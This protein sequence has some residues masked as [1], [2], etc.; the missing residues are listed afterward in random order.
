MMAPVNGTAHNAVLQGETPLAETN[1]F[2]RSPQDDRETTSDHSAGNGM[3]DNSGP[4]LEDGQS[5]AARTDP[6]DRPRVVIVGCSGHARVVVDAIEAAGHFAIAG[7]LDTFKSPGVEMLGYEVIGTEEDIGPLLEAGLCDYAFVA[8][9]DNWTRAEVVRRLRR[10]APSVQFCT[11]IH[12]SAI[13]ARDVQ[14]GIGTVVL[15]GAVVNTGANIGEFCILNTSSSLDHDSIML[16]FSSLGPRAVTGGG[17]RVGRY[18]AIGIGATVSHDLQIG[19]G[20]VLGAGGVAVGNIPSDVVAYG[21]PAQSVRS[22]KPWDSYLRYSAS[23]TGAPSSGNLSLPRGHSE[24][25]KLISSNSEEWDSY[26]SDIPHDFFHTR[27]CHLIHENSTDTAWLAVVE[28]GDRRIVWPYIM[29]PIDERGELFD[30]TSVYGYPGPLCHGLKDGSE[31]EMDAWRSILALW[32][33]QNVISAFTRFSPVLANQE[34]LTR[35]REVMPETA[36]T[37]GPVRM[38]STVLIDLSGD[39]DTIRGRYERSVRGKLRR[40]AGAGIETEWDPSWRYFDDFL[41]VYYGTMKRN[42]A[43]RFYLF[44]TQHFRTFKE[45]SGDHTCLLVARIRDEVVGGAM[46]IEYGGVVNLY[47]LGSDERFAALSPST[48]IIDEVQRWAQARGNRYVHLGGGRGGSE[49]D[50]LFKFKRKFSQDIRPFYTGRWIINEREYASLS[51]SRRH[52][53]TALGKTVDESF[54]PLYRSPFR[55]NDPQ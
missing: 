28:Q 13:V 30:V 22:R 20:T 23:D 36:S 14:I 18:S 29:R 37:G 33:E 12:P 54:F 45:I 11:V 51:Q 43:S 19:D 41:R 10:A 16:D 52:R 35:L 47:L 4:A 42:Q 38:G 40:A 17:V 27:S 21:I 48:T 39:Q 55:G 9:G 26:L 25:L 32:R 1:M 53:A 3:N 31:F 7:L 2:A 24:T 15:A 5:F 49:D 6:V 50:T 34:W 46:L 8:I 44:S